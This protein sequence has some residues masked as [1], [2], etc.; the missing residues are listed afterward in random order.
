MA[1]GL[2]F[3]FEL[4]PKGAIQFGSEEGVFL[5]PN[6]S[7]HKNGFV[8]RAIRMLISLMDVLRPKLVFTH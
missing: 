6:S 3:L 8:S 7:N 2:V 1:N 4:G 5:A